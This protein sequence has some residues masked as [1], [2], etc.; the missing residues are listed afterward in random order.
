MKLTEDKTTK[1][2]YLVQLYA[3]FSGTKSQLAS[4]SQLTQKKNQIE[5]RAVHMQKLPIIMSQPETN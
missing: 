1:H 4:T 5:E 3:N 2:K